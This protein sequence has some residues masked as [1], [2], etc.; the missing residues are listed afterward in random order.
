MILTL[1]TISKLVNAYGFWI[2]LL[3]VALDNIGIPGYPGGFTIYLMGAMCKLN[4][5][6]VFTAIVVGVVAASVVMLIMYWFAYKLEDLS[7][8]KLSK[9][10]NF[11]K[12]YEKVKNII[13]KYGGVGIVLLRLIPTVRVFSSVILGFL[14]TDYKQYV[15]YTVLGNILYTAYSLGIG[16]FCTSLFV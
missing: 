2:L 4:L 7:N 1:D 10:K 12:I 8:N 15:V 11:N 16:Y 5:L 6:N 9:N 13:K 3:F 14:K